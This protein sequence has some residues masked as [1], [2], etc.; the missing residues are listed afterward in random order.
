VKVCRAH[1]SRAEVLMDRA[2]SFLPDS[3]YSAIKFLYAWVKV[4]H[5]PRMAWVTSELQTFIL[6]VILWARH[7]LISI[8]WISKKH[9]VGSTNKS[10]LSTQKSSYVDMLFQNTRHLTTYLVSRKSFKNFFRQRLNILLGAFAKLRKVTI[11]FVVSVC[12]P[13]R[14]FFRLHK[15]TW[16]PLDGF[17][18][19]LI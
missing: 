10:V 3:S 11:S 12:R 17:S 16:L 2:L 18:W 15:K 14:S 5:R 13:V 1:F 19:N 4:L 9:G 7:C 6:C 8:Q